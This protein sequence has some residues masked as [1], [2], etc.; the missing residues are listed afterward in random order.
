MTRPTVDA[1]GWPKSQVSPTRNRTR[2][3]HPFDCEI[4]LWFREIDQHHLGVFLH[5]LEDDFAAVWGNVEVTNIEIRREIGQL[6]LSAGFGVNQPQIFM[7]NVS[8]QEYEST[9]SSQQDGESMGCRCATSISPV[10]L[11]LFY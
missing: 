1:G 7:P 2:L 3:P 9:P 8:L 5:S 6:P 11:P 10:R 4:G